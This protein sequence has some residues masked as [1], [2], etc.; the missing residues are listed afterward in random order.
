[1]NNFITNQP[2]KDLK[3]RINQLISKSNEMKFLVGFFYFS[4]VREL[5]EGLKSNQ[6]FLL[7]VLVGLDV[8]KEIY[9]LIEYSNK[10]NLSD[11]EKIN[12]FFNSLSNS[13]NSEL[14]DTKDF[15]EQVKFFINLI[16]ND[17]L[18]IRKTFEPNHSKIYLFKLKEEQIGRNCLFITGS[19]NLTR[20]GL[21][22][23]NEF[24][25]EISDYGFED[26]EK[27]FDELWDDAI[28]LTEDT[29]KKNRLIEILNNETHIKEI[30]PF[31]A[32]C[33]VIH[34]YIISSPRK[35]IG[36]TILEILDRNGYKKYN[37]QLDAVK[38]A[39]SIIEQ[40]N[41][42][43][44]ADVVGLG[45]T[46][47]ACAV[48][49]HL[50][51]RGIVICPPGLIGDDNK[52]EGWR[53]YLEQ[54]QLY[55]WEVRS[56][57]DLENTL[58][59]VNSRD[60][61]EVVIVDEA[62]RFR[63]QD[64]KG[65]ELLKNICRNRK[66]ILL[67]ATPF[68]NKP[69]DILSLLSLFIIPKQSSIT[70]DN[71]LVTKF[72]HLNRL[73]DDLATIKK[74]H[75]STD[76]KKRKR[77]KDIYKNLFEEDHIDMSKVKRKTTYLA[78]QIRAM[79]EPV[80]IRRNRLDLIKNP[81]Y[82]NEVKE[83][84]KVENPNEWFYELTEEQSKFYDEII[85]KYFADPENGG[86]FNGTIYRPYEYESGIEKTLFDSELKRTML[87]NREFIQQ[88]N[89]FDIMRRLLV[90][91]FESSFG[92]FK[93]SIINFKEITLNAFE[94]IKKT[95]NGDPLNGEYI[96]DRDLL[97][98][99]LD[100]EPEEIEKRLIEYEK[101]IA[102]GVYPKRY[103]RYKIKDFKNGK[104]FIDDIK[105]DLKLF[106]EIL[107][108]L[109]ELKLLENDP[110]VE[111]LIKNIEGEFSKSPNQNEPKRK[112]VI[113]SEYA[114]T[115]HYVNE[116]LMQLNSE[117][118]KRTLAVTGS[119]PLSKISLINKNFDASANEQL[120]EYD[121]LLST[122]KL[123]EGFNLNRAG[124]VINYDIPWNPVRVIQRL[125]R[126]NRISKKVFE[127][128][129]IVNFFPTEKGAEFVKSR[130]IAQ[131]KMFLIHNT[132][133]EDSKIF[134]IDEEPTPAKLYDKI[135]Q[136]PETMESESF[137]T[138][139]YQLYYEFKEKYP[140]IM[141]SLKNFPKRVK[142]TKPFKEDEMIVVFKKSKLF[143]ATA[144]KNE[145]DFEI[146]ESALE[147]VFDKIECEPNTPALQIDDDFWIMYER[148]K[149]SRKYNRVTGSE[150]SLENKALQNLNYLLREDGNSKLSELKK[151]IRILREDI[152]DYG[153]LPDYT[154]RRIAYMETK[155]DELEEAINELNQL[156]MELGEDYLEKEKAKMSQ[157]DKEL[158]IAIRNKDVFH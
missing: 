149:T 9:G 103:K 143:V 28:L 66:V 133:G 2:T 49:K 122:D 97:E 6:D 51:S 82:K 11:E 155:K 100:L 141:N 74:Y 63:N 152:L 23:Q 53:K 22:F 102:Q 138:K 153:T 59:F 37:Y 75:N 62:H 126:I 30:T 79:I 87:E 7:K 157:Q 33:L 57:G 119:I 130:E 121:I 48:A 44:I 50:R 18:I 144:R 137:D 113:F 65:Y 110:K 94:F 88:R 71:N 98:R 145:N 64:T 92:A 93:K 151:F 1:M 5:Y 10:N 15:Y 115:V 132:L 128:L 32:F 73:F 123:S 142:V 154:L 118:H 12:Y 117:L 70:L 69:E 36:H 106:D 114:D 14:F 89:L 8:S 90:K 111:C 58:E 140:E 129:Y 108:K 39:L 156:K 56:L 21:T 85:T 84:S 99:I 91:R 146:N 83:L 34:S 17:K 96:L 107:K 13:I 43:L 42:V 120:D 78:K 20:A 24:N 35:E 38:Q 135:M 95:G 67:T 125:G 104:E 54:F 41:G 127:S 158:I 16:I 27:Y 112:I 148:V 31:E 80:T 116:K 131:N 139:M 3:R 52:T 147:L 45:K 47:I 76:S 29:E 150:L 72:R 86:T 26:A 134:D 40:H 77:A 55:D 105:S 19:S 124:M 68:N 81:L 109:D 25:V 101:Q 46:I 61:I 60:D 136:N 4:G